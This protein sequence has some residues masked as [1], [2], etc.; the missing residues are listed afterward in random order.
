MSPETHGWDTLLIW[1]SYN[2]GTFTAK[3]GVVP[4][5]IPNHRA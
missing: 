2:H 1:F 5:L 3:I 4:L